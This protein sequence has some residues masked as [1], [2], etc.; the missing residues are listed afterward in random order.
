M[1]LCSSSHPSPGAEG[2]IRQSHPLKR[3]LSSTLAQLAVISTSDAAW[4]TQVFVRVSK[5]AWL[6]VGQEQHLT[7]CLHPLS[8]SCTVGELVRTPLW[9]SQP[10]HHLFAHT[11]DIIAGLLL[12]SMRLHSLNGSTG[13]V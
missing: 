12:F 9:T 10:I 3:S 7:V 5:F 1:S 8:L 4:F 13:T 11:S 2:I 6:D